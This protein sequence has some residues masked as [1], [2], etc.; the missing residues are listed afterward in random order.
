MRCFPHNCHRCFLAI[1]D[2]YH[3]DYRG[4]YYTVFPEN[5]HSIKN[6]FRLKKSNSEHFF[7]QKSFFILQST[8]EKSPTLG[9]ELWWG[10]IVTVRQ[11]DCCDSRRRRAISLK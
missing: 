5:R 7:E 3:N 10:V 11:Q 4:T 6:Q 2:H 1:E 8:V 9:I